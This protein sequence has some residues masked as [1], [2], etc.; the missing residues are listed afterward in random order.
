M[1][2]DRQGLPKVTSKENSDSSKWQVSVEQIMKRMIHTLNHMM[3]LRAYFIPDDKR[4]LLKE[5]VK[6]I[7]LFDVAGTL[8]M[9][10]DRDFESGMGSVT[11]RE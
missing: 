7:I 2:D 9:A 1:L 10:G 11:T 4:G 8:L 6:R 5:L 3:M